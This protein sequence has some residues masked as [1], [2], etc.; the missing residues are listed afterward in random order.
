MKWRGCFG[1]CV[2]SDTCG[3]WEI[4]YSLSLWL[5]NRKRG[6]PLSA[7]GDL[8]RFFPFSPLLHHIEC[9]CWN[10][11][12]NDSEW[13]LAIIGPR[14][15]L[16]CKLANHANA[17]SLLHSLPSFTHCG[18]TH[19]HTHTLVMISLQYLPVI[20]ALTQIWMKGLKPEGNHLPQPNKVFAE[21]HVWV[22]SQQVGLI[23]RTPTG[24]ASGLKLTMKCKLITE[25]AHL[26][27]TK[28]TYWWRN[29]KVRLLQTLAKLAEHRVFQQLCHNWPNSINAGTK[30]AQTRFT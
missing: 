3:I 5:Q 14:S 9:A 25:V 23:H 19:T 22:S 10:L 16:V 2:N 4:R 26:M 1:D 17:L 8:W 28:Q 20:P 24:A 12:E 7:F 18:D 21:G 6:E 29:W 15:A 13:T 11:W 27:K 30:A